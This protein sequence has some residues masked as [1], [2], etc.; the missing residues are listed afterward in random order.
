LGS[1]TLEECRARPYS[2]QPSPVSPRAPDPYAGIGYL[3]LAR[4]GLVPYA[5]FRAE[6]AKLSATGLADSETSRDGSTL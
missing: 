3:A 5:Q 6:L 4:V 2:S 1:T